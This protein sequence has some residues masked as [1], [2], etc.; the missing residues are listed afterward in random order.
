[1]LSSPSEFWRTDLIMD[2]PQDYHGLPGYNHFSSSTVREGGHWRALLGT[3]VKVE[4][5]SIALPEA[6][7]IFWGKPPF[8]LDTFLPDTFIC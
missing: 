8:L 5:Q 2:S 4:V 6:W 7:V 1:M 3:L